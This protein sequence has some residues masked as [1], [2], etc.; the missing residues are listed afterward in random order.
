MVKFVPLGMV[1]M[2]SLL[3]K[4][5]Y[6]TDR[7]GNTLKEGDYV[8]IYPEHTNKMRIATIDCFRTLSFLDGWDV[9]VHPSFVHPHHRYSFNSCSLKKLTIEEVTLILLE[10]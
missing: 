4:K 6:P 8:S 2:M 3:N 10:N 7:Y 5:K 1:F 9:L